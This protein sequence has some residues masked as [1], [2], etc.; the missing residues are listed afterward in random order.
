[1]EP[2]VFLTRLQSAIDLLRG[3]NT[4]LQQ[5]LMSVLDSFWELWPTWLQ[6]MVALWA[7]MNMALKVLTVGRWRSCIF[8]LACC[9]D[10]TWYPV[11]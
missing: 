10:G 7:D 2:R 9:A 5:H 4:A 8:C 1:M 3:L 11:R 6:L